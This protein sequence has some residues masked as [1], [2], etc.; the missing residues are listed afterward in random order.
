MPVFRNTCRLHVCT[1]IQEIK[2][3]GLYIKIY[4]NLSIAVAFIKDLA[5]VKRKIFIRV[6]LMDS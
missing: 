5:A 3:I 2:Y 6:W 1:T 4:L